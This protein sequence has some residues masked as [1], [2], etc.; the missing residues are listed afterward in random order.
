MHTANSSIALQTV[1]KHV[2]IIMD[3]NGR[4]AQQR[5]KNRSAGH[6]EGV[7]SV[8]RITEAALQAGV[9]CVTL[10]AFSSENWQRPET[11]VI[12]LMELFLFVLKRE[13]KKLHKNNIR[14]QIIGARNKFNNK[15]LKALE[16][17]EQLTANNKAMCLFVAADY[18]GKWDI[19]NATKQICAKV[20]SGEITSDQVDEQL[21]SQYVAMAEYPLPDLFIRTGGEKRISNFLIWQLAYAELYFTDIL[22][23]DFGKEQFADALKW[24]ESRQRRFGKTGEQIE[25]MQQPDETEDQLLNQQ[26]NPKGSDA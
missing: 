3:G 1:P 23:P 26:T 10:F 14:L 11:E 15:I 6:K 20:A 8:R 25:A 21:L 17:A 9:E 24:F 22:W 4:W 2:A 19:V 16:D 7:K 5:G 12:L 13:V 18:G